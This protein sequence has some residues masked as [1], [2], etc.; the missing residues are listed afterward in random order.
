MPAEVNSPVGNYGGR[1]RGRPGIHAP[2]QPPLRFRQRIGDITGLPQRAPA[3]RPL[4]PA[5]GR[6]DPDL[7][8]PRQQYDRVGNERKVQ[9]DDK[10]DCGQPDDSDKYVPAG[11]E[12]PA[13]RRRLRPVGQLR[14]GFRFGKVRR[15]YCCARAAKVVGDGGP[16][17]RQS[18][19]LG[20]GRR[21]LTRSAVWDPAGRAASPPAGS[22]TAPSARWPASGKRTA[23]RRLR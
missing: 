23:T 1:Q 9:P 11:N 15:H 21:S 17:L 19:C 8:L 5:P 3:R 12:P 13:A 4:R 22:S 2:G 7:R 16:A 10:A 14:P 6:A 18:S 20:T